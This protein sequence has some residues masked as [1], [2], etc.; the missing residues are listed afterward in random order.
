MVD[1]SDLKVA[2]CHDASCASSTISTL[3]NTGRVGLSASITIGAD[4]LGLISYYDE[5]NGNLKVAHAA[6]PPVRHDRDG[7]WR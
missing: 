5:S 7:P 4:G 2:L 6:A 3:D 1:P